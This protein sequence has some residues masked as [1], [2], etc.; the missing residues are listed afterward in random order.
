M[1]R[2]GYLLNDCSADKVDGGWRAAVSAATDT[3]RE[4]LGPA[5]HSCYLTGSVAR[6]LA[7]AG[8]SDLD[9]IAVTGRGWG[10]TD[11]A[12]VP[13]AEDELR[14]SFPVASE[15]GLEIWPMEWLS[16]A[17]PETWIFPFILKTHTLCLS[18]SDLGVDIRRYRV[19]PEIARDDLMQLDS[20]IRE[21]SRELERA[22]GLRSVRYW[23]RRISKNVL[24]AG[25]GLV[26]LD[27][28]RYTRDADLCLSAFL[29]RFPEL[30]R[31]MTAFG[32]VVVAGEPVSR[33]EMIRL[34]E[35]VREWI[36][37][38]ADGWLADHG[39]HPRRSGSGGGPAPGPPASRSPR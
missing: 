33:K 27:V 39:G 2:H 29:D 8:R 10:E 6:G 11:V 19:E 5:M 38:R 22:E 13:G 1:D 18:G 9:L 15:V 23:S 3:C 24:R 35:R 4:G 30:A 37:P 21:A 14:N 17:T 31:D 20:D 25:F 12:W 7:V 28:G 26:M 16:G 34:L 32:R 36:V